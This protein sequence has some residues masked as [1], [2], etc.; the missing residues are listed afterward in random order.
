LRGGR[1][2]ENSNGY[3]FDRLANRL[4]GHQLIG[5]VTTGIGFKD[6]EKLAA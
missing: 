6:G 2:Q 4:N 5:D 1:C 3:T